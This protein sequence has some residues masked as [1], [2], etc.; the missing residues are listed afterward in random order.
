MKFTIHKV[1]TIILAILSFPTLI[2]A[3]P[4]IDPHSPT[5]KHDWTFKL[6][7][8]HHCTGKPAEFAGVGSSKC[9]SNLPSEAAKR[10]FKGHID[11]AC[12]VNL[13]SDDHCGHDHRLD[14]IRSNIDD[15]C[16]KVS[17][18]KK[19]IQSFDVTCS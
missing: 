5:V 4:P 19:D 17:G 9:H 15:N 3:A 16:K 7:Q 10:F 18:K 2:S 13:Y 1:Y 6:Y 12:I 14:D 11:P 8:K